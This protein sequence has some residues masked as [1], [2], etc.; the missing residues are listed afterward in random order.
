M[1]YR[2]RDVNK[3]EVRVWSRDK[4][5]NERAVQHALYTAKIFN[6]RCTTVYVLSMKLLLYFNFNWKYMHTHRIVVPC[7]SFPSLLNL[8]SRAGCH[9]SLAWPRFICQYQNH[10]KRSYSVFFKLPPSLPREIKLL[11]GTCV[12]VCGPRDNEWSC[13]YACACPSRVLRP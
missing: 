4:C 9:F 5:K 12:P 7:C 2:N 11:R 10:Q 6:V 3:E 13:I 1:W 8:P